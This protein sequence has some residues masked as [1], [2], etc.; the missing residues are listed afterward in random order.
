MPAR[1]GHFKILP[2]DGMLDVKNPNTV[3]LDV[4]ANRESDALR[5]GLE[6]LKWLYGRWA[7]N[8]GSPWIASL[9]K[10]FMAAVEA[11]LTYFDRGTGMLIEKAVEAV[12]TN[13]ANWRGDF[14]YDPGHPMAQ[15]G[16]V[17]AGNRGDQ[18]E[19]PGPMFLLTFHEVL[20]GITIEY[21]TGDWQYKDQATAW[22]FLGLAAVLM[23]EIAQTC[24]WA[25]KGQ[26]PNLNVELDRI[27]AE[28]NRE[29]M[30]G[31]LASLT[32]AGQA[33][34][35]GHPVEF[36]TEPKKKG[37][38]KADLT[39]P[40]WVMGDATG[41]LYVECTCFKR[42]VKEM[43][44]FK[45]LSEAITRGWKEKAKKF[46]DQF[47]PGIITLDASSVFLDREFGRHFRR[48]LFTS[49]QLEMPH[50]HRR[51]VGLYSLA[52]DMEMLQHE[53]YNRGLLGLFASLL[54][55]REAR[56]RDIK[57]FLVY[58][59][60]QVIVDT[61]RHA[62]MLPRRGVLAWRSEDWDEPLLRKAVCLCVPACPKEVPPDVRPP[63]HVYLV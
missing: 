29:A 21:L 1:P 50:G 49:W 16:K 55:S 34:S 15:L 30:Q 27:F 5:Y 57:G 14:K 28:G 46:H 43:N 24:Y 62:M 2:G 38:E 3:Y 4:P 33:L 56:E 20:E 13:L 48:D 26:G 59:G 52:E 19:F 8:D 53:S 22:T 35:W 11:A 12:Q 37:N 40:D 45:A 7:Q 36:I 54:Y 41:R 42:P 44:D 61:V 18:L 10:R 23:G 51:D 6:S 39:T 63:V 47:C 9:D 31:Q 60:Q 17:L 32:L 25:S 58:Q